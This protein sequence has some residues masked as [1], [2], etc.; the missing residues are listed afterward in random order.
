MIVSRK[1]KAAP[2]SKNGAVAASFKLIQNYLVTQFI[3]QTLF[4]SI[5]AVESEIHDHFCAK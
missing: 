1:K 4:L 5:H 2:C 3:L